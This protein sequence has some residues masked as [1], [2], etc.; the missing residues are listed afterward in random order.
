VTSKAYTAL[1]WIVWQVGKRAVRRK[2]ARADRSKVVAAVTIA[3]VVLAGIAFA[4]HDD[5]G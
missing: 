3:A 2:L 4:G 1:G 5:E